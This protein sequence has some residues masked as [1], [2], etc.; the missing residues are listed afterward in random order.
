MLIRNAIAS[1]LISGFAVI[2]LASVSLAVSCDRHNFES[3]Y[4]PSG[5]MIPTIEVNDRVLIDK[6]IYRSSQPKRGDII[7]SNPT[8]TLQ[9][10]NYQDPFIARI[11]G[12]PGE[13]IQIKQG[14]VFI[15]K[16]TIKES[17]IQEA[18][19]YNWGPVKIARNSYAVLGDNRNNSYDSHY[20]GLVTRN[21]IIGKA[22]AIWF[23]L[24]RKRSLV[25]S[26]L[27]NC[28]LFQI[29]PVGKM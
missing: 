6:S 20:W 22:I 15:N 24:A 18:P 4:I 26:P 11:I 25:D 13:S 10:Q 23:P 9:Q 2:G 16:K 29:E 27:P 19:A 7:I 5:S 12:L 28:P 8:P 3:R 1:T 14:K 17:Y 21:L